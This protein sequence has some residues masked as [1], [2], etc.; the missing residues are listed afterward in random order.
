MLPPTDFDTLSVT[1]LSESGVFGCILKKN[2]FA[3]AF[4]K[5][6]AG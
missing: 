6:L 2:C 1:S 3:S 5:L 4:G